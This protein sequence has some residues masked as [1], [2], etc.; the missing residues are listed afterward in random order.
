[1][2]TT[3]I[4]GATVIDGTGSPATASDVLLADGKIAMTAERGQLRDADRVVDADGLVLAP[5]FLDAHSHADNA[6]FLTGIDAAKLSQGVTTEVIGNCGF[7]PA[8]C[9]PGRR[10][11]IERLCGRLF[12]DLPYDWSTVDELY[13]TSDA[14]GYPTN[15]RPLAGHHVIRAAVLGT[16]D[17]RPT[18]DELTQMKAELSAALDAGAAGLSSGL[19]YPP[20]M[21]ADADE[22]AT[23]AGVLPPGSVYASH[24]R[25]EGGRLL[26]GVSEAIEV[27]RRA[28]CRLQVSHLK[29]AG[30]SAWGSVKQALRLMDEAWAEGIRVHHDVYPYE[31]NSTLLSACLPP[32]FHADGHAATM[33]RLR[34]PEVLRRAEHDI[35]ADDG[36]WENWVA[37]SG[38]DRVLVASAGNADVEGRTLAELAEQR[39]QHPFRVLTD[40]LVA[41]ELTAWMSVFAMSATDVTD[42]LLHPRALIGSDGA[43][44]GGGGKPHPRGFGTFTRVLARYVRE[45]GLLS[46][47][48]A[49][50]KMTSRTASAFGL[51]GRGVIVAGAA[52]DVVL[53]DPTTVAD[54]ATFTAPT[55]ISAGIELVVVNGRIAFES[56]EVTGLRAGRRL[57]R[58]NLGETPCNE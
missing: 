14:R 54:R 15:V 6:P 20:G 44:P 27:A 34:D 30:R 29:A 37:G 11:E 45:F 7:S 26:D 51:P 32:W 19:I 35:A 23:L 36:S 1:M 58:A 53:F 9:P 33:E 57:R 25:N 56:G 42:A 2:P 49:I 10:A 4:R 18:A 41:S 17:R 12:P 21:Y 3:L 22:L 55:L 48:E 38:W 24:L 8:P 5:G 50:A 16:A 40:L 43:P 47:E 52:A 39:R 28:G 46:W 13:G 31:A